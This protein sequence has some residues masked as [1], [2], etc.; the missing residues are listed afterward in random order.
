MAPLIEN[1]KTLYPVVVQHAET[2]QI[3]MMAFADEE[4][5]TLTRSTGRAHFYSRSRHALWEKG[6]TSGNVLAVQDIIP[7][8]DNDSFIYLVTNYNPACHRGTTSCFDQ[9]PAAAPNPLAR[10]QSYIGERLHASA[11]T[12]YT[13]QLLQGPLER[14]LKKIGE[15]AI[16]VIVAAATNTQTQGADMVWES[17]DLLYHLSVLLTRT[18]VTLQSLDQELIRRHE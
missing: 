4:A 13:A 7:D 9:S 12:S 15:E 3:L 6:L 14:L 10:L 2:L 8:C 1:D 16:E 5:L 18:G 17:A 11:D